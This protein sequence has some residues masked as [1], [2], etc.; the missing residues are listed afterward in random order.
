VALRGEGKAPPAEAAFCA[1]LRQLTFAVLDNVSASGVRLLPALA[2][3]PGPADQSGG[4]RSSR[5][6]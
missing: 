3:M 5:R 6:G 1:R 4:A 2:W